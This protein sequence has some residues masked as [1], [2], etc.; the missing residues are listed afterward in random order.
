GSHRARSSTPWA[1]P[2]CARSSRGSPEPPP[3]W[4]GPPPTREPVPP[5]GPTHSAPR[6]GAGRNRPQC[7][8]TPVHHDAQDTLATTPRTPRATAAPAPAGPPHTTGEAMNARILVVDDDAAL[9][10]MIGIVLTAEGFEPVFCYDGATAVDTF[11]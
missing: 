11:R 8:W 7:R 5:G 1:P 10:E 9:S 6:C 4:P 2:S 3:R